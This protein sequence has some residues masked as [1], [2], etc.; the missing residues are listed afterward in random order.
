MDKSQKTSKLLTGI[1]RGFT[2]KLRYRDESCKGAR[3][4]KKYGSRRCQR[5][6]Q[7]GLWALPLG[8]ASPSFEAPPHTVEMVESK[9]MGSDITDMWIPMLTVKFDCSPHDQQRLLDAW[10]AWGIPLDQQWARSE[11]LFGVDELTDLSAYLAS[12][13]MYAKDTQLELP[14]DSA[15]GGSLSVLAQGRESESPSEPHQT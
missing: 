12:E 4:V 8:A 15:T 10:E 1:C 11:Q 6:R 13:P 9:A 3:E 2:G 5:V 7:V 14:F